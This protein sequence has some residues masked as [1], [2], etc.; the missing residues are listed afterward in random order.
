MLAKTGGRVIQKN[1]NL[2]CWATY[3]VV[4]DFLNLRMLEKSVVS[5]G[6][7]FQI[8]TVRLQKR[9]SGGVGTPL[10]LKQTPITVV[11][12]YEAGA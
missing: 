6:K 10:F 5:D 1:F 3:S 7:L 11:L 4:T 8:L 9:M 12:C 2:Q